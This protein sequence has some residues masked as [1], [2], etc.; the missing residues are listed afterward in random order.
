MR[1]VRYIQRVTT[2]YVSMGDEKRR[3]V[4]VKK[5]LTIQYYDQ[6]KDIWTS[7][8]LRDISAGGLSF[9]VDMPYTVGDILQIHLKLPTKPTEWFDLE[10]KIVSLHGM[11]LGM[12]VLHMVFTSISESALREIEA[13]INW[14]LKQQGGSQ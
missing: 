12:T 10:A 5:A 14:L 11:P 2:H 4:R 9:V 1:G 13:Y 8:L 6:G 7:S 3:A